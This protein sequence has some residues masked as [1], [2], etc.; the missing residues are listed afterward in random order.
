MLSILRRINV[1]MKIILFR[2]EWFCSRTSSEIR[3][4]E[5]LYRGI[6]P[7]L[8]CVKIVNGFNSIGP[9]RI[10]S[11]RMELQQVAKLLRH[12]H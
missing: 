2:S 5:I 4:T 6:V 11:I 12:F 3:H 8:N 10:L 7:Y 9:I 1:V